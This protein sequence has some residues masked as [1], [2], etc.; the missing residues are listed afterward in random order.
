MLNFNIAPLIWLGLLI[1]F[2]IVV[3]IT[4]KWGIKKLFSIF[5]VDET[6]YKVLNIV[7]SIIKVVLTAGVIIFI[8]SRIFFHDVTIKSY[9]DDVPRMIEENNQKMLNEAKP[10]DPNKIE[11]LNKQHE[12]ERKQEVEDR[13]REKQKNERDEF[14]RFLDTL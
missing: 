14:Q 9:S 7:Y 12:L 13:I 4:S 5:E 10:T 11:M 1:V 6:W 3:F 8:A 2:I